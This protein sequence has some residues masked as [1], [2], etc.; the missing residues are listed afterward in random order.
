MQDRF[1]D[2]KEVI[3]SR[4]SKQTN[5]IMAKGEVTKDRQ[6]HGQ[7]ETDKRQTIS[8]PNGN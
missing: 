1:E 5:N 6:N 8:W 4:T 3:R 7:R 2:I